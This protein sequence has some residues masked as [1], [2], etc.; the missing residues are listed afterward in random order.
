M[1]RLNNEFTVALVATHGLVVVR[2][3][4]SIQILFYIEVSIAYVV[5][6]VIRNLE[7]IRQF[8]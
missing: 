5:M 3:C 4:F 1:Q 8:V 2:L 7:K 6:V